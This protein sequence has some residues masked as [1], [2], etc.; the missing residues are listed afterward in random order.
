M[1]E[2]DWPKSDGDILYASEVNNL[3]NKLAILYTGADINTSTTGTASATYELADVTT[4]KGDYVSISIYGQSVCGTSASTSGAVDLSIEIKEIGGSYSTVVSG[5]YDFATQ[6]NA[7]GERG[8]SKN[9]SVFRGIVQL[10]AGMKTNGFKV[11][12]G[13]ISS[14]ASATFTNKQ[15]V[16]EFI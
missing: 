1:G 2:G 8:G 6:G 15:V 9:C 5:T 7:A 3:F 10:T 16:V 11:R 14:G 12:I 13:S 4:I